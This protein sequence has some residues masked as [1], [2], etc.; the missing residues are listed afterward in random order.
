[1]SPPASA[2]QAG[3]SFIDWPD[4]PKATWYRDHERTDMAAPDAP[5]SHIVTYRPEIRIRVLIPPW[6]DPDEWFGRAHAGW[7]E[8]VPWL[9]CWT[10]PCGDALMDIELV[11]SSAAIE[12]ADEHPLPPRGDQFG[13]GP[14]EG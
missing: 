1:M 2:A 10:L 9:E 5:V 8:W 14:R 12:R 11:G 4:P 7:N 3:E 13:D 6:V